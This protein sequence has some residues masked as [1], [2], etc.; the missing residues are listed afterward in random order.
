[1]STRVFTYPKSLSNQHRKKPKDSQFIIKQETGMKTI[2]Q[3]S[4]EFPIVSS[5]TLCPTQ[6]SSAVFNLGLIFLV[7]SIISYDMIYSLLL[8][9]SNFS[10]FLVMLP[11]IADKTVL[12]AAVIMAQKG[13][14]S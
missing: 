11:R 14:W 5:V 7:L 1:M 2:N 12:E 9:F 13:L 10:I 3:F 6:E 8:M 4:D